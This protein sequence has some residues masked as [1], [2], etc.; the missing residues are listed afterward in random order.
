M[1]VSMLDHLAWADAQAVA[2]LRSLPE[3]S[4]QRAQGTRLYAHLA[5]AAHVWHARLEGRAPEH[6]VWPEL[7]LEAAT[8][9]ATASVA[10]L[11]AIASGDAEALARE[12]EYR[13]TSG[14][15]FTNTV[16]DILAHVVVHGSHHRG[17]LALLVRQGGGAPAATDY[18]VFARG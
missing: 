17:Q 9:L 7:T 12:V 6:S 3:D 4:E 11:R 1:L 10:G 15:T 8:A 16:A 5:A 14:H 13:T 2:A 18:I